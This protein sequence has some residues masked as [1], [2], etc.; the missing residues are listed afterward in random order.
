MP[1]AACVW[2]VGVREI[3]VPCATRTRG[4][5]AVRGFWRFWA[6]SFGLVGED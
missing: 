5:C 3:A 6:S 2:F 4:A 1:L